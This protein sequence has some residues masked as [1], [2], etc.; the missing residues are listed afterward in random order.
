MYS[1]VLSF[2][3]SSELGWAFHFLASDGQVE[4]CLTDLENRSIRFVAEA[5]DAARLIERLYLR[6]GLRWCER[7]RVN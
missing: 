6:G 3:N 5:A 4:D 1:H 7:S 2:T